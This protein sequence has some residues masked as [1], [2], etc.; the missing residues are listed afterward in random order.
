VTG[1]D[2][3]ELLARSLRRAVG[4]GP[5]EAVDRALADVGWREALAEWGMPAAALLFAEQGAVP[6]ASTAL[7]DVLAHGLGLADPVAVALPA[8]SSLAPPGRLRAGTLTVAGVATGR[9]GRA[10]RTVVAASDGAAHRL[11][12]VP[13]ELL[14]RTPLGGIDPDAGLLALTGDVPVGSCT[15]VADGARWA[16]AC[17]AAQVALAAEQVGLGR[18][19]LALAR[20]HALS[21]EQFG[22]PIASFQA[23]RHRLADTL[24]ALEG[25]D[26]AVSAVA[27]MATERAA[28][29]STLVAHAALAKALAG[30]A[31]RTAARHCQQVLAGVGFTAEHRFHHFLRRALLLDELLGSARVLTR[32]IGA[33]AIRTARVPVDLPL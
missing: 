21:R 9:A 25:A 19:M 2:E 26:A 10:A 29:P 23:V 15:E 17:A 13:S 4:A 24:L 30:R 16:L 22:R 6:A 5:S 31:T 3:R 27:A 11:L 12:A 20:E 33:E 1:S 18:G 14:E 28:E 8:V 7:D 32:Q